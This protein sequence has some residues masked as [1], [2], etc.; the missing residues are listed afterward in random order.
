MIYPN[1]AIGKYQKDD[2]QVFGGIFGKQ[3]N[4]DITFILHYDFNYK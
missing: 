1:P 2:E 4:L 3:Y